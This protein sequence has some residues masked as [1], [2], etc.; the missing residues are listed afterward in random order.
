MTDKTDREVTLPLS[1]EQPA[2]R[3]RGAEGDST[4]AG[5]QGTLISGDGEFVDRVEPAAP[6]LRAGS[7]L[8]KYEIRRLLGRGAMGAVYLAFDPMIEREVAIKVLPPEVA[9]RPTALTRF[10]TEARSTGK[11]GHP[12]AVSIF[13]ISEHNGQ[14]YIVMELLTGGSVA[15][16][17]K[18]GALPW[19]EA[20]RITAEAAEGLAAAHVAGLVHRD[21]KPENLMMTQDGVVKVVDFGL[22]KLVDAAND[23]LNTVTKA[24]TILG[25]PQY[26]SPEQFESSTVGPRSDIYS[27]GGTLFR[28]LTGRLP[29][30]DAA[31]VLQVMLA[32]SNKPILP[33]RNPLRN[34]ARL[35]WD[36]RFDA[37]HFREVTSRF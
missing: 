32:H 4:M 12:N 20:C 29:Y 7:K 16:R 26:M 34:N 36:R 13:D 21:I 5:E 14:Y 8:G 30:Q 28:L 11:I 22:S 1:T 2:V 19:K 31:G 37:T 18:D 9:S 33:G 6:T 24:G 35:S 10:L 23:T 3:N 25:T 27:L 15:D 17:A